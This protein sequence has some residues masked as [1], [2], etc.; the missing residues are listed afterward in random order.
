M[1]VSEAQMTDNMDKMWARSVRDLSYDIEDIIDKFMVRVRSHPSSRLHGIRGL[2]VRSLGLLTMAKIRRQI[3]TDI[4]YIK[5]FVAEVAERRQ[6]YG[7]DDIIDQPMAHAIDPRLHVLDVKLRVR[8]TKDMY[9]DFNLGLENLYSVKQVTVK[10]GCTGSRRCEVDSA[11]ADIMRA[12]LKN[13]NNPMLD[14]TR[15]F[16]YELDEA[17]NHGTTH[18]R[19]TAA[20][21]RRLASLPP[22][23][24]TNGKAVTHRADAPSPSPARPH[25]RAQAE[26]PP[27]PPPRD[28]HPISRGRRGRAAVAAPNIIGSPCRHQRM[29]QLPASQC[30]A[31]AVLRRQR[32]QP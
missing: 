26:A 18:S 28:R 24:A 20:R 22:G 32:Q 3:A 23:A 8:E 11:E 15:C 7:V 29:A 13:P 25:G 17:R 5:K 10:I 27:G 6:R 16:E 31:A 12:I 9:G 21:S 19:R 2:F 30:R 14:A 4:E 1:R